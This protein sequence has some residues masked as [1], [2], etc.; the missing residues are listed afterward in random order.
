MTLP[1]GPVGDSLKGTLGS[2]SR[3]LF[4]LDVWVKDLGLTF[5]LRLGPQAWGVVYESCLPSGL[6]QNGEPLETPAV[7]TGKEMEVLGKLGSFYRLML[8]VHRP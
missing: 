1:R 6:S 5:I 8:H 3:L 7:V 2:A 4:P